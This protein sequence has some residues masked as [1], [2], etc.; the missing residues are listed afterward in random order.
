MRAV[1]AVLFCRVRVN[2]LVE[3]MR[4]DGFFTDCEK[5]QH[6]GFKSTRFIRVKSLS[7]K[8]LAVN[9]IFLFIA[10]RLCECPASK[11][12]LNIPMDLVICI[13]FF[14]SRIDLNSKIDSRVSTE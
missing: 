1:C 8:L 13:V 11:S 7:L 9:S 12:N 10:S 14:S 5:Q 4:I 6:I 3:R 2:L